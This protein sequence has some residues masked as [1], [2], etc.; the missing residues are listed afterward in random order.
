MRFEVAS[1]YAVRLPAGSVDAVFFHNVLQHLG[2]PPAALA[3]A[4]RVLRPGGVIGVRD[5]DF[6]STVRAPDGPL[7]PEEVYELPVDLDCTAWR[8]EPGH[9]I[10][11]AVSSADFPNVW[12]TP[13]PGSNLLYRSQAYPSRLVLPLVRTKPRQDEVTFAPSPTT[14]GVHQG[15]PDAPPW[16]IAHDVLRDRTGLRIVTRDVSRPRPDTEITYDA[17]LDL[18]ASNRDPADVVAKGSH[19]QR[20]ARPDGITIVDAGCTIRSTETAFHVII[21]LHV[22]ADGRPHH[23]RRWVRSF[24]RVLL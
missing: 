11:L 23:Q 1:A 9:R 8:F 16:E 4:H 10:R 21:D 15:A 7:L 18:W 22:V 19:L 3:E 13:F 12:P 2:D 24:P 5:S 17:R 14:V 20:I 6:G